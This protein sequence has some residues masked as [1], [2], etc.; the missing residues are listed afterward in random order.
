MPNAQPASPVRIERLATQANVETRSDHLRLQLAGEGAFL[1]H[2]FWLRHNAPEDVHE[3]TRERI[4][5]A[6][7]IPLEIHPQSVAV[8]GSQLVID[9]GNARSRYELSWLAEHAYAHEEKA[10]VPPSSDVTKIELHAADFTNLDALREAAHAL[11]RE[12]GAVVVRG[13]GEDT[14]ALIAAFE[15][16]GLAVRGTHFGRIEDLRTDNTTNQNTDQLGYTDAPIDLHTDQPFLDEPPRYQMLHGLRAADE[17]GESI[18]VDARAAARY[19]RQV[20]EEA[21][22]IITTTPVTFHRKQKAFERIVTS[23]L[24]AVDAT[25]ALQRVRH[26]YFTFAPFAL[27]FDQMESFYRAY[28]R[29]SRV[30]HERAHQWRF[31]LAPGDFVLYDNHR[32]LHARTGFRG[33]RWVRGIYFDETA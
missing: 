32:T 2:Y 28:Q 26:S 1:F 5:D 31:L 16:G 12:H 8:V 27:R 11:T 6:R 14:E 29:F 23:P 30:I 13:A 17:G 24:L 10:L 4:L 7:S 3:K 15:R 18:L 20:D 33:P 21:F 19:L 9:W 25:G 22:R